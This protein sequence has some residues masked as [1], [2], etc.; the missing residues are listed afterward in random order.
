MKVIAA[1]RQQLGSVFS[2]LYRPLTY[3]E[4]LVLEPHILDFGAFEILS[5]ESLTLSVKSNNNANVLK[6][7]MVQ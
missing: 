6:I 5:I 3:I 1:P 2:D 4:G 7:I